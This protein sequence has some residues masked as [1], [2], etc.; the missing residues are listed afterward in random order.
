MR[1]SSAA[2]QIAAERRR[3]HEAF[4]MKLSDKDKTLVENALRLASLEYA[5]DVAKLRQDKGGARLADQ[6]DTQAKDADRIAD[7]FETAD[8][9]VL[10]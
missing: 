7:L 8:E 5:K 9:V 6:F 4:T 2:K 1:R 3:V 10:R